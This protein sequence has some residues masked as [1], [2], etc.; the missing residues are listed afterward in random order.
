M[1][2]FGSVVLISIRLVANLIRCLVSA[3]KFFSQTT[4]GRTP[5]PA[6]A[7]LLNPPASKIEHFRLSSSSSTISL[8]SGSISL[9][10]FYV[11]VFVVLVV[12]ELYCL[13]PGQDRELFFWSLPCR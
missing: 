13:F 12:S 9:L 1:R 11:S 5:I 8:L 4:L 7:S 2:I 3:V 6:P 10:V